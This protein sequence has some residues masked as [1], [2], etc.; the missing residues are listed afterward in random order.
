MMMLHN[1]S[2]LVTDRSGTANLNVVTFYL[3]AKC[4]LRVHM[5][6][7]PNKAK[8]PRTRA[9]ITASKDDISL[10]DSVEWSSNAKT[11]Y[12]KH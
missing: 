3:K 4:Y 6:A 1:N 5:Q 10:G 12:H 8:Y 11:N 2:G 7:G 9:A